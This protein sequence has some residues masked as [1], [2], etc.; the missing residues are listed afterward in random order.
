M[1]Q[2]CT[3]E[4]QNDPPTEFM[5]EVKLLS[6]VNLLFLNYFWWTRGSFSYFI[7]SA[8]P[9]RTAYSEILS[10]MAAH[11]TAGSPLQAGEISEFEPG[12]TCLQSSLATIEPQLLISK[13]V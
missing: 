10:Q 4:G 11:L 7:S 3:M 9:Q 8:T 1:G 12:T 6:E 2:S 13:C 5:T